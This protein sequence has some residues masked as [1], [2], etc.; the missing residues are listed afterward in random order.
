MEEGEDPISG[1][2]R[3][4]ADTENATWYSAHENYVNSG[5]SPITIIKG[6]ATTTTSAHMLH[7][8]VGLPATGIFM[9]GAY[10]DWEFMG[11]G[12]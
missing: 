12:A 7:T 5:V 3:Y 1:I 4:V 2:I 6:S 11:D 10:A 9:M 8:E